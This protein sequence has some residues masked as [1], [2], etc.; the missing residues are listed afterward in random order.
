MKGSGCMNIRVMSKN[1]A[2]MYTNLKYIKPCAIISI[3]C[4]ND[5]APA[6]RDNDNVKAIL[7]LYFNDINRPYKDLEPRQEQLKGLKEFVD[8]IKENEEIEELIIHCTAGISR[9]A[10]VAA[11]ICQY[12]NLDELEII[13]NNHQYVPNTLVYELAIKE[14]GLTWDANKF[15]YY[16]SMNKSAREFIEIPED[17]QSLFKRIEENDNGSD[18][19]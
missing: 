16:L 6:F 5:T 14:L 15:I 18:K 4:L 13:W 10:A 12:L 8:T 2:L 7:K 3:N 17:I 9:S 1:E 11:A 19:I